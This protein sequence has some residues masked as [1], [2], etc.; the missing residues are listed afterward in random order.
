MLPSPYRRP[1][2]PRPPLRES[3]VERAVLLG[4][5]WLTMW[6]LFKVLD[7]LSPP[8]MGDCA[9]PLRRTLAGLASPTPRVREGSWWPTHVSH[10]AGHG[11]RH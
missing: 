11:G 3:N 4:L 5:F 2:S 8:M 10:P 6:G 1:R 9:A 7:P